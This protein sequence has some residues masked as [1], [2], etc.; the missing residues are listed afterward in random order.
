MKAKTVVGI[1]VAVVKL[2]PYQDL[3]PQH[4]EFSARG[5]AGALAGQIRAGLWGCIRVWSLDTRLGASITRGTKYV[6]R[7]AWRHIKCTHWVATWS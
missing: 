7:R 6:N 1:I 3:G 2:G 4:I 5:A